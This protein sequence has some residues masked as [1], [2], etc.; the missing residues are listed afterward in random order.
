M[1]TEKVVLSGLTTMVVGQA[2]E[3]SADCTSGFGDGWAAGSRQ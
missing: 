3:E 2:A 1:T